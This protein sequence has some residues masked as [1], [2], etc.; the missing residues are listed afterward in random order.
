MYEPRHQ[1]EPTLGISAWT[2]D[3]QLSGDGTAFYS[4]ESAAATVHLLLPLTV[5]S[6]IAECL[7]RIQ[8][9]P[10]IDVACSSSA[11]SS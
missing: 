10:R 7:A 1:A 6:S 5:S 4:A 8:S 3:Y 2:H 11:S 9:R